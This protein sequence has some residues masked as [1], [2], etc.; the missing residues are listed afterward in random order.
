MQSHLSRG[1][2]QRLSK[3]IGVDNEVGTKLGVSLRSSCPCDVWGPDV[4]LGHPAYVKRGSL[5][6]RGISVS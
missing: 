3:G 5:V 2:L 1:V 4:G 6:V